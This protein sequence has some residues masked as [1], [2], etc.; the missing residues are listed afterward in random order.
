[1]EETNILKTF[2]DLLH[3]NVEQF[4]MKVM[5]AE[6]IYDFVLTYFVP[7]NEYNDLY[8]CYKDNKK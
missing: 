5:S 3:I 6:S 8:Q 7:L 1:M 2:K 4:D